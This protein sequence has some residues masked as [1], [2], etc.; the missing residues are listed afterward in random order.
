MAHA[1]Y[2]VG[3]TGAATASYT[4]AVR[5]QPAPSTHPLNSTSPP[6]NGSPSPDARGVAPPVSADGGGGSGGSGGRTG[7]AEARRSGACSTS[8]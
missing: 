1:A 5:K 6:P 3:A 4:Q 2:F 8:M 7:P